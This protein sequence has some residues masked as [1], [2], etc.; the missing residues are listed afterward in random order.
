MI[1]RPGIDAALRSPSYG[2]FQI[3]GQ[4]SGQCGA[5]SVREFASDEFVSEG[6]QLK[7]FTAFVASSRTLRSAL[8]AHDWATFASAYNG[9]NFRVNNYDTNL[10]AAFARRRGHP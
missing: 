6:N 8:Q 3:L 7:H 5:A 2:S 1:L 10:A 9:P 4:N